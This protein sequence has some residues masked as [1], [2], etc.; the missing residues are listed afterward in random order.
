MALR[1]K[2]NNPMAQLSKAAQMYEKHF[3]NEMV[4]AMRTSVPK[5]GLVEE[6]MGQRIYTQNLDQE[7]VKSWVARGGVGLAKIIE[8]QMLE[9]FGI[10]PPAPKPN[11]PAPGTFKIDQKQSAQPNKLEFDIKASQP[12]SALQL[13]WAGK[14]STWVPSGETGS[15]HLL[16]KHKDFDSV[17]SLPKKPQNIESGMDLASGA[18]LLNMDPSQAIR[19]EIRNQVIGA[20]A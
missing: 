20:K 8:T 4:K 13:P 2:N 3:L 9:Q 10:R 7:Y 18:L 19:M 5:A 1:P 17:W 12:Q 16:L 14:V 6:S 11:G 15:G